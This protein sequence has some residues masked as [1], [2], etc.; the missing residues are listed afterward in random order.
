M[1]INSNDTLK[2]LSLSYHSPGMSKSLHNTSQLSKV[3]NNKSNTVSP[4]IV[5]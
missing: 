5:S 1:S 4:N 2:S 3:Q